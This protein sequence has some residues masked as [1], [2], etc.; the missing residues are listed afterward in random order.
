MEIGEFV[1]DNDRFDSGQ[2]IRADNKMMTVTKIKWLDSFP[3]A[4][5]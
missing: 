3:L 2:F 5:E 4:A 1:S